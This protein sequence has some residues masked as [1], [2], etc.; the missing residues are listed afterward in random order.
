R[1]PDH[2]CAVPRDLALTPE[3]AL[4]AAAQIG[5]PR[6][7]SIDLTRFMCTATHC[8]PVVGGVLVHKD[9]GH[10]TRAFSASLGAFLLRD[11]RRLMRAW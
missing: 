5:P 7:Q 4:A 3:P 8:L 10:L 6:A 2:A 11:L 9:R 1:S